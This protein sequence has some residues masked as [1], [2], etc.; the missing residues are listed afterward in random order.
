MTAGTLIFPA[1]APTAAGALSLD[2]KLVGF[3]V[4]VIYGAAL[5]SSGV[6]ASLVR[7]AGGCRASQVALLLMACGCA[8]AAFPSLPAIAIGSVLIGFGYGLPNP[9]AAHLLSRFTDRRHRS[10]IFSVKQAGVPLGGVLVGLAAPG[11]A[12]ALGWQAPLLATAALALVLLAAIQPLRADWDDDRSADVGY[13]SA[14]GNSR[15]LLR[16]RSF[17]CLMVAMVLLAAVQLCVSTFAVVALVE[18]LKFDQVE[19]GAIFSATLAAS[20]VGRIFWGWL[21]DRLRNGVVVLFIIVAG[22]LFGSVFAYGLRPDTPPLAIVAVFVLL[23]MTA[24]G[25]NGVLIAE[26]VRLS[27]SHR[28]A[29]AIATLVGFSYLGVLLGPSLFVA[30]I[31]RTGGVLPTFPA[32]AGAAILALAA[33]AAARSSRRPVR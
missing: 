8:I 25:W 31:D 29:D 13:G 5:L 26:A 2:P 4:S 7:R 12:L 23:G 6:A 14:L 22:I 20:V 32:I 30:A 1:V 27:P 18:E 16:D 15:A 33:L 11:L 10:L 19:A 24:I 9:A 21:A 28:V 17:V 3:Q